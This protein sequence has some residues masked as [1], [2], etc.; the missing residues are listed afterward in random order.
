MGG[1]SKNPQNP[2]EFI[3]YIMNHLEGQYV[4]YHVCSSLNEALSMINR[5]ERDWKFE[6]T[7]VCGGCKDGECGKEGSCKKLGAVIP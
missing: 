1:I 3:A 6:S 5:V 7:S 4:T 2:L